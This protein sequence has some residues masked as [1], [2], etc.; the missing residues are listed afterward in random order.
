MKYLSFFV[1]GIIF[2]ILFFQWKN[3]DKVTNSVQ[4]HVIEQVKSEQ[5]NHYFEENHHSNQTEQ[6]KSNHSSLENEFST[7]Q[8]ASQVEELSSENVVVPYVQNNQK[9]PDYYLTKKEAKNQGWIPS[10]GNLCE[11]VPNQVI[12]GDVFTNREKTLP[13]KNGRIYY[14]ADLNYSCGRRGK[15]RLVFS[16]DGLI[17]VTYD[18][19]R[20][21]EERRR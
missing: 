9:L 18:H 13:T 12:G 6:Q 17:Y 5:K 15:D 19:Y 4:N 14:E 16:N 7:S 21:F 8:N 2:T 11:V 3:I 1:L 10:K 20:T